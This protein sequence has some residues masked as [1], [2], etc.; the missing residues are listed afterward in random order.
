MFIGLNETDT[1]R[2]KTLGEDFLFLVHPYAALAFALKESCLYAIRK[3]VAGRLFV[4]DDDAVNQ[5][6]G[7]M[8]FGFL[9]SAIVQTYRVSVYQKSAE[10]LT[11]P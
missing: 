4:I 1:I 5:Q 8:S 6:V 7:V 9:P 10:T 11:Q 3:A 2:F